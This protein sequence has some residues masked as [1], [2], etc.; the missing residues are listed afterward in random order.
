MDKAAMSRAIGKVAKK[1]SQ[2]MDETAMSR[3]IG[4]VAKT[5][6]WTKQP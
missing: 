4:K 5:R 3:A 1:K 6:S 2:I